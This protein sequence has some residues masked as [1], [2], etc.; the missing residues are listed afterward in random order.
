MRG[1]QAPRRRSRACRPLRRHRGN[2]TAPLQRRARGREVDA[3]PRLARDLCNAAVAAAGSA[4]WACLCEWR[5]LSSCDGAALSRRPARRGG[6]RMKTVRLARR[7]RYRILPPGGRLVHWTLAASAARAEVGGAGSAA[8]GWRI[9]AAAQAQS[10]MSALGL[11]PS[12]ARLGTSRVFLKQEKVAGWRAP[13]PLRC[14]SRPRASLQCLQLEA[15]RTAMV[16][17]FVVRMQAGA[18]TAHLCLRATCVQTRVL[19]SSARHGGPAPPGLQT[20]LCA[21]R[22]P[23]ALRALRCRVT[24]LALADAARSCCARGSGPPARA[25]RRVRGGAFRGEA[26]LAVRALNALLGTDPRPCQLQSG[27]RCSCRARGPKRPS[28]WL[29]SSAGRATPCA[30]PRRRAATLQRFRSNSAS[31]CSNGKLSSRSLMP[32][33]TALTRSAGWRP[34][35]ASCSTTPLPR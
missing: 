20:G 7:R 17:K 1:L 35:I 12:E 33:C 21:G 13:R 16:L 34:S 10:L 22:S 8:C 27:R 31:R 3:R 6:R 28:G 32:S 4:K 26:P 30:R 24:L 29:R 11:D 2:A 9:A 5:T 19:R 18:R 23:P 25:G 15:A 14:T